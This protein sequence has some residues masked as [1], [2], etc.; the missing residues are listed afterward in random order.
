[1]E[2]DRDNVARII[3][4]TKSHYL[5][6]TYNEESNAYFTEAKRESNAS[7]HNL[8]EIKEGDYE[9]T[10]KEDLSSVI[11]SMVNLQMQKQRT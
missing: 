4:K 7:K 2:V 3:M 6:E 9:P 8:L 10:M 1:M 5:R 11:G